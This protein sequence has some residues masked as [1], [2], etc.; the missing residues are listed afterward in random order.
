MSTFTFKFRFEQSS[1][2]QEH[3]PCCDE[4]C[5]EEDTMTETTETESEPHTSDEEFIVSDE[6]DIACE[7]VSSEQE[8]EFTEQD[9]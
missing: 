5:C 1:D 9:I 8:A 4:C 6:A 2:E 7:H 3:F